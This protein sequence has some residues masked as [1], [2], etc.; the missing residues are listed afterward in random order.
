LHR[1]IAAYEGALPGST[2]IRFDFPTAALF[3]AA[4]H[5]AGDSIRTIHQ[6]LQSR[7]ETLYP[8]KRCPCLTTI[9]CYVRS[10][11]PL[12]S[13]KKEEVRA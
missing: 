3:I 11:P 9:R 1:W 4:G 2:K 5:F 13:E 6:A 8:G 7:W 12:S 10:L